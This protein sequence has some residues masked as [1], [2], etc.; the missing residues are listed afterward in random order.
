MP[1]R[2]HRNPEQRPPAHLDA[3]RLRPQHRERGVL[4]HDRLTTSLPSQG[5]TFRRATPDDAPRIASQKLAPDARWLLELD[6]QIAATGG[7]LF[8]YNPPYG[9]I[10]MAVAEPFR[11]RG[12]G[13]YLVQELKRTC[14]QQGNTPA[15]R[16]NTNNLPSRKTLQKAGFVPC[17]HILTASL[18]K[19]R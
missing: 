5:A 18:P 13:S 11:R 6:G 10:F 16:C 19:A 7:I 3:P 9:D 4:F 8:H 12:L 17:G 1:L 14:H 2:A 15:A